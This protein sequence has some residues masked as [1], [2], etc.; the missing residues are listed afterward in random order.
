MFLYVDVQNI[1]KIPQVNCP[2]LIIHVSSHQTYFLCYIPASVNLI[3]QTWLIP[4]AF[5]HCLFILHT[6]S[7][8][9]LQLLFFFL[10]ISSL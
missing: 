4:F 9:V 10:T 7:L 8:V 2:V 3:I 5:N 6:P 1:D